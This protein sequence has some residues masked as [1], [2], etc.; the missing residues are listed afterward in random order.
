MSRPSFKERFGEIDQPA[1]DLSRV[2]TIGDWSFRITG[3]SEPLCEALDPRWGGFVSPDSDL[4]P[5]TPEIRVGDAGSRHWLKP[6]RGED[7]RVE[8]CPGEAPGGGPLTVSYGFALARPEAVLWKVALSQRDQEP[9]D[10]T[11]EN[12]V[13]YVIAETAVDFG[14]MALHGAGVIEEDEVVIFAGGSGAGKSTAVELSSPRPC[15]GDDYALVAPMGGR[16]CAAAV[17]FDNSERAPSD[18]VRGWLPLNHVWRL[19]QD[20]IDK[21]ESAP[22]TLASA[23]L[24]SCVALP[25]AM[26]HRTDDLLRN[27]DRLIKDDKFG[28]LRFRKEPDFWQKIAATAGSKRG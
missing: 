21:A 1:G 20:E 12:A 22:P 14:G 6:K 25:W 3:L 19:F 4:P 28:H 24:M 27:A 16:W 13:R 10:R 23:S 8:S 15:L 2:L 17:P 11:L 18:P 7:Y 9:I 5:G 26:P